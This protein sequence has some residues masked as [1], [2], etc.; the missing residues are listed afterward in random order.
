MT[1]MPIVPWQRFLSMS[2]LHSLTNRNLLPSRFNSM[3]ISI[4]Y[5]IKRL[6]PLSNFLR[7]YCTIINISKMERLYFNHSIPNLVFIF[8]KNTFS[9]IKFQKK[10]FLC[11]INKNPFLW[12]FIGKIRD[13]GSNFSHESRF[14]R[15][16][17]TLQT[18]EIFSFGILLYEEI[19]WLLIFD[20]KK[21][22]A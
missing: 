16:L 7:I 22:F 4:T 11:C 3:L 1:T 18:K 13:R 17:A 2:L 21:D 12:I 20:K 10:K 19:L 6:P 8:L 9:L 14:A 15:L 5:L